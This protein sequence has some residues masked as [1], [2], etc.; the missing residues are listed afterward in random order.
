MAWTDGRVERL[1]EL[2]KDGLSASRIA[3]DLGGF[4]HAPDGGRNAVI[5]KLH[6]IGLSVGGG[7]YVPQ[8]AGEK[9]VRKPK[10]RL[11]KNPKPPKPAN[12]SLRPR[13]TKATP[14]RLEQAQA[15]YRAAAEATEPSPYASACA[16]T[17]LQ[18]T[19]ETCRWPLG[20]PSTSEFRFCGML[21][22]GGLPYCAPHCRIAYQPLGDR[23]P[24]EVTE[25]ERQRRRKQATENLLNRRHA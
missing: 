20:D 23:Q 15:N 14:E 13:P 7:P 11:P 17:L 19:A 9:I 21:P 1:K 16:V 2:Q 5:G 24:R 3:A 4:G 22:C 6:R 8:K 12:G 25:L 10:P 18:L